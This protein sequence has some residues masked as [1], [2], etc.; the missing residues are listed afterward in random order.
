VVRVILAADGDGLPSAV[1]VYPRRPA[2]GPLQVIA[3]EANSRPMGGNVPLQ[4]VDL[5]RDGWTDLQV[6]T[7]GGSA[8]EIFTV[9]TYH[10]RLRRFVA[11]TAVAT[12][13]NPEPVRG[14]PCIRWFWSGGMAGLDHTSGDTC[15]T[16]N[17]WVHV[18][19]ETSDELTGRS[20]PGVYLFE[21]IVRLWRGGRLRV[22]RVDTVRYSVTGGARR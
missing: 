14:R 2:P 13:A 10:P 1:R 5:N 6:W 9:L 21:R 18:R 7:D 15:W 11:D 19:L 17:R 8:G 22:A 3:L 20:S 16:G 4:G 12:L